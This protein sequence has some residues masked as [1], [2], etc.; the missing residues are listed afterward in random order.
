MKLLFIAHETS[1]TGAPMVLLHFLKWVK[2][3]KPEIIVDILAINT[4]NLEEEFKNSC[5]HYY[6]YHILTKPKKITIF[7][8]L[9]I[10]FGLLKKRNYDEE[11]L[12]SLSGN[13][14]SLIYANTIASVKLACRITSKNINSKLLVHVHE[15]NALINIMLPDFN[16]Y[17]RSIDQFIV[18]SKL[19]KTSLVNNW[20]IKPNCINVVYECTEIDKVVAKDSKD[21]S[22][23]FIVG[24]SG[25]VHWRKGYDVFLQVA[26]YINSNYPNANI[27]FVW[28][29][30]VLSN[31]KNI[32][33]ADIQ[34]LE[35][36]NK[37]FFTGEVENPSHYYN[38]FDIFVMPSREDP[39]PL[40]CIEV[41]MLG[42][43]I[44]SFDKAVG[45]N[46]ILIQGG[47]FIAPYLS[48]ESMANHIIDYYNNPDLIK[49]HG[50]INKKVFS[51]FTP[52]NICPQL[53]EIIE[54]QI[55]A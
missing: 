14:Y 47:G 33:E 9:L 49:K 20:F 25:T 29:G 38:D 6:P 26:R 41:G 30:R 18:P 5:M 15:L 2:I 45:T 8:R 17:L 46:E 36:Q 27:K 32:L 43:P 52:E 54:A 10:K 50:A 28:V 40:V 1:R 35:L 37:V 4:G 12:Q 34:K 39:F 16:D 55:K 23:T 42:K 21:I 7:Q 53:F 11:L 13:N 31:E 51:Q 48:I 24:A 19:V 3:N 44:I 22:K